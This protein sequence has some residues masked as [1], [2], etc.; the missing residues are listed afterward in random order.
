MND[1]NPLQW[2]LNFIMFVNEI[3]Q[4]WGL[5][6]YGKFDLWICNFT[7]ITI[8]LQT[9]TDS[10]RPFSIWKRDF[11]DPPTPNYI[12]NED[13]GEMS[14]GCVWFVS[15]GFSFFFFG[16]TGSLLQYTSF[17]CCLTACG[18]FVPRPGIKPTTPE[19]ESGFLATG[20][21]GKSPYGVFWSKQNNFQISQQHLACLLKVKH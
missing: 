17:S 21:L 2:L 20:P 18:I 15:C 12:T 7:K 9:K 19:L 3:K 16:C 11:R 10:K 8:N 5:K 4:Y 1:K 13:I 14:V 6:D